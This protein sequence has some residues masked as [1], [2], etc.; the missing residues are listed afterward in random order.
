MSK[1]YNGKCYIAKFKI[2][3]KYK[4]YGN[5]DFKEGEGIVIT[6][7]DNIVYG[8]ISNNRWLRLSFEEA[9]LYLKVIKVENPSN[10]SSDKVYNSYISN[11][12]RTVF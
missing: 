7:R 9:K 6:I 4:S 3:L 11:Y 2:D 10:C 12:N 8:T 5:T 1:N